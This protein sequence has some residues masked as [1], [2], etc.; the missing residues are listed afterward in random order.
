[1]TNRRAL[2]AAMARSQYFA[3]GTSTGAGAE[4]SATLLSRAWP[5]KLD[6]DPGPGSSSR[7]RG[8]GQQPPQSQP[9][10]FR[11]KLELQDLY[12]CRTDV[13]DLRAQHDALV[14]QRG[15]RQR[16]FEALQEALLGAALARAEPS[17]AEERRYMLA[18]MAAVDE[19]RKAETKYQSSLRAMVRRARG[20]HAVAQDEVQSM[21]RML[22]KCARE[23]GRARKYERRMHQQKEVLVVELARVRG[24]QERV[25][26]SRARQL[27]QVRGWGTNTC[28][29]R[30]GGRQEIP[31]QM[32]YR[33]RR[34]RDEQENPGAGWSELIEKAPM[35]SGMVLM[36]VMLVSAVLAGAAAAQHGR[37]AA[38]A[39][40]LP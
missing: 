32:D 18:Q 25:A 7:S 23:M 9:A 2:A 12:E 26:R 20:S 36:L 16:R 1:M 33:D 37:R 40:G 29:G 27:E 34:G 22:R 24:M 13:A 39:R 6:P 4:P 28:V 15:A 5:P 11:R 17:C 31:R 35:D 30:G 3:G 21:Q 10:V 38:A 19:A 14:A 8:P